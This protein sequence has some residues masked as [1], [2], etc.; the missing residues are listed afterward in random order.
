MITEIIF[1]ALEAVLALAVTIAAVY[2][3]N[4]LKQRLD[5]KQEHMVRQI[6]ADGVL[7][8]QQVYKDYSGK[9]R[10]A[11]ALDRIMFALDERGIDVERKQIETLIESTVKHLKKEFEDLWYED[12]DE[13]E[14][15]KE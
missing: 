3:S 7:F 10:F 11:Y 2:A 5:E 8:A 13:D 4:Y 14:D 15:D 12:E 1:E 9:E 6:V